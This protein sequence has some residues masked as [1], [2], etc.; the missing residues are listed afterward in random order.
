[1]TCEGRYT[2]TLVYHFVMLQHF[3]VG[4]HIHWRMNFPNFFLKILEKMAKSVQDGREDQVDTRLY[5][6]G[7]I[8]ILVLKK[9]KRKGMTW[10]ELLKQLHKE[11]T[12][13]KKTEAPS[14][15]KGPKRS[16]KTSPSRNSV[17]R[18]QAEKST[19][20][21]A[22]SSTEE[23]TG[24]LDEETHFTQAQTS[25]HKNLS[26]LVDETNIAQIGDDTLLENF[27]KNPHKKRNNSDVGKEPQPPQGMEPHPAPVQEEAMA[28]E[29]EPEIEG[30]AEEKE[31]AGEEEEPEEE[32]PEEEELEEE[33]EEPKQEEMEEEEEELEEEEPKEE[34]PEEE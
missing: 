11:S 33:E 13:E 18:N 2:R 22:S 28:Q 15:R 10:E 16:G 21:K 34:E 4:R 27:I 9:L 7:L 3:D 14:T 31:D 5:H 25:K 20:E 29:E 1:M 12:Q 32:E 23:K 8:K 26:I 19:E 6:H 17:K 30:G 24:T